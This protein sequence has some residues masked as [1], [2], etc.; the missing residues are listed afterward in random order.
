MFVLGVLVGVEQGNGGGV[1]AGVEEGAGFLIEVV[2]EGDGS[3]DVAVF[4]EAFVDF[5]CLLVEG[6]R[7]LVFEGEEVGTALVADDEEVAEAF[8]HEK[9]DACA[10]SLKEGIG[11]AGGSETEVDRG[12]VGVE[13]GAGEEAGTEDGSLFAGEEVDGGGLGDFAGKSEGLGFFGI[14]EDEG[15]LVLRMK[16][17]AGEEGVGGVPALRDV[18]AQF[19]RRDPFRHGNTQSAGGEDFD[20]AWLGV[21][22]GP[23]PAVC[24]GASCIYAKLEHGSSFRWAL[25]AFSGVVSIGKGRSAGRQKPLGGVILPLWL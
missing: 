7:A 3:E 14:G 1:D 12:E 25:C 5:D 15:G 19:G 11:A 8:R 16:F 23:A 20:E 10:F 13:C 9:G 2:V 22:F 21:V 4:V 24:E 18:D 6:A 17:V